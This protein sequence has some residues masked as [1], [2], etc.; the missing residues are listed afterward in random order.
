VLQCVAVC[1]SVLQSH[2]GISTLAVVRT[3]CVAVC[4]SVLQSHLGISTLAVVSTRTR[5]NDLKCRREYGGM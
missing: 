1:C 3:K 5:Q 2:L 4:C